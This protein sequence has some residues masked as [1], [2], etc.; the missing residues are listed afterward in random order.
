MK[1][2]KDIYMILICFILIFLQGC[3]YLPS[4]LMDDPNEDKSKLELTQ[5]VLDCFSEEDGTALKALFCAK[6][7]GLEDLDEQIQTGFDLFKGKVVSFNEDLLGAGGKSTEYGKIVKL[8]RSWP[9][10]DIV[11]DSGDK[12]EIYIN[13]NVIYEDD[14]NKEGVTDMTITS[15]DGTK[16]QIGYGWPSYNDDGLQLSYKIVTAFSENDMDRLKSALST[17]TQDIGDINEQIQNGFKFFEGKATMGK[18]RRGN[19]IYDDGN[20][21]YHT[22]VHEDEIVKD[23][24]PTRT[25]ITAFIVNIE[26]DSGKIYSMEYYADL[27]NMDNKSLEGISQITISNEEGKKLVIGEKID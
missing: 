3:D 12:Y 25:S 22:T 23:N 18:V 26:T 2:S 13:Q 1:F 11:T 27:L 19:K 8:D 6:T 17:K 21:D 15:S 10:E 20:H 9:V 4:R 24:E 5:K 14:K 16:I 7:K